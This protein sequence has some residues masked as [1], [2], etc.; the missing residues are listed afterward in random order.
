VRRASAQWSPRVCPVTVMKPKLR[1]EAPLAR[2]TYSI[3]TTFRPARAATQACAKPTT[4][5]PTT[6]RSNPSGMGRAGAGRARVGER[7]MPTPYPKHLTVC[8][9]FGARPVERR[10]VQRHARVTFDLD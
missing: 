3:T 5:A 2:G 4:P 6:A 7:R 8:W 1:I 10:A 9:S